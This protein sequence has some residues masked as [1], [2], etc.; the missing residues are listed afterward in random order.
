MI[1][2]GQKQGQAEIDNAVNPINLEGLLSGD[3]RKPKPAKVEEEEDDDE[4]EE[5]DGFDWSLGVSNWFN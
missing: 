1:L 3:V 2:K 4:D 5:E